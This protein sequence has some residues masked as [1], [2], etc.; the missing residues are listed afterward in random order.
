MPSLTDRDLLRLSGVG[1]TQQTTPGV[2]VLINDCNT[3]AA[4]S[5]GLS[6]VSEQTP[7]SSYAD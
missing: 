2:A 5:E 7:L 4:N 1:R 6:P 3:K